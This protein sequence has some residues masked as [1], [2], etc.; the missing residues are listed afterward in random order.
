MFH[1]IW[2]AKLEKKKDTYEICNALLDVSSNKK[3]L[4]AVVQVIHLYTHDYSQYIFT[5]S[6]HLGYNT[7]LDIFTIWRDPHNK[8]YLFSL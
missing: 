1:S 3:K 4:F 6:H 7:I 2:K 8:S 5:K